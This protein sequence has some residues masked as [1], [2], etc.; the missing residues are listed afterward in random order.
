MKKSIYSIIVIFTIISC[1]EVD[2]PYITGVKGEFATNLGETPKIEFL[3]SGNTEKFTINTN[4][5]W[6]ATT[7][8][9][10]WIKI[11][12][13]SGRSG[14]HEISIEAIENTSHKDRTAVVTI[15]AEDDTLVDD[16]FKESIDISQSKNE[17]LNIVNPP[18][19]TF[20]AEG[21]EFTMTVLGNTGNPTVEISEEAKSWFENITQPA[22]RGIINYVYKFKVHKNTSF[23][24]RS[25]TVTITSGNLHESYE[26]HQHKNILFTVTNSLPI[27]ATLST[28]NHTFTVN[29][30]EN[31]GAPTVEVMGNWITLVGT[32]KTNLKE[33]IYTF[34]VDRNIS[35]LS[36]R[37]GITVKS[38][39]QIPVVINVEQEGVENE[40]VLHNPSDASIS[41]KVSANSKEIYFN[42]TFDWRAE[43]TYNTVS[44]WCT[45]STYSGRAGDNNWFVVH[46]PSNWG[47]G[48][49][50]FAEI[51]IISSSG[52]SVKVVKV[53]QGQ[54]R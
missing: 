20:I 4:L 17:S 52:N 43:V 16:V 41:F 36:R 26:F 9:G 54:E 25:G 8:S 24:D 15:T 39:Q 6:S 45:L 34:N 53:R 1:K 49:A 48:G 51:R 44:G 21:E 32:S 23:A 19:R 14:E 38:G 2:V 29:V 10:D 11:S 7:E 3:V 12:P 35:A 28:G 18:S 40:I 33:T 50:R 27:G 22:V 42:S 47:D 5:N 13:A 30:S 31:S 37:G 46:V